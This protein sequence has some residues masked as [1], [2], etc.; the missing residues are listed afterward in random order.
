[1]ARAHTGKDKIVKFEGH[2]HGWI[3]SVL[4]S[5]QPPEAVMGSRI[6]PSKIKGSTGIPDSVLDEIIIAPWN[7]LE[8]LTKIVSRNKNE[9]A[10]IITE[11]VMCNGGTIPP[12]DGFLKGL[13]EL[14][15]KNDILL[16]FDEVI[17][18]FRLA[19]GGAQEYFGVKPD[20]AA[21][22]KA[23]GGGVPISAFAGT[24]EVMQQV[25][26]G[27]AFQ[28]GTYNANPLCC[29]AALGN[30]TELERN[31]GEA[32]KHM[33]KMGNILADGM[34]EILEKGSIE[35]IV[36]NT[37]PVFSVH[38]TKMKKPRD[39]RDAYKGDDNKS[40]MLKE[41]MAGRGVVLNPARFDSSFVS[42]VHSKQDIEKTLSVFEDSIRAI[43]QK[44]N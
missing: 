7:D 43:G 31:N 10:A 17:T 9:V 20:L 35:A 24:Q 22:S 18:G 42:A 16:I 27:K 26:E 39:I 38:F 32:Y 1:V 12:D 4:I 5:R 44:V 30:L 14:T 21:F 29:A 25:S 28:P 11:P 6:S 23:I 33:H 34:R 3:D 40:R 37:G 41:E 8:L 13:R 15:E 36:L 19:L 2:Y